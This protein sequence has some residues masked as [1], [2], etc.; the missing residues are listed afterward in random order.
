[1]RENIRGETA[2]VQFFPCIGRD[3]QHI[4]PLRQQI[5]VKLAVYA[6]PG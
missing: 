5:G 3:R 6:V 1:M 4:V 2:P